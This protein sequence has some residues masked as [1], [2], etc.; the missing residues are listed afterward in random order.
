MLIHYTDWSQIPTGT[1]M[2][3]RNYTLSSPIIPQTLTHIIGTHS[4]TRTDPLM[5]TCTVH[6]ITNKKE[7]FYTTHTLSHYIRTRLAKSE[8]TTLKKCGFL[9]T[10]H[11]KPNLAL[12]KL[13]LLKKYD[14]KA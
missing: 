13:K 7:P 3:S 9:F 14:V 2:N 12:C 10:F 6:C 5:N 1:H 4:L 8:N 11:I